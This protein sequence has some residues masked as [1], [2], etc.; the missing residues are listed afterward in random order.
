[1]GFPSLARET[2][3]KNRARRIDAA[4]DKKQM[5]VLRLTT[6]HLHP[7]DEDLSPGTPELHPSDEDLSPGTPELHP[8]DEDLSLG[9][10]EL[11]N[12]WGPFSLRMTD[13]Y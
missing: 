13:F 5:Q 7:S 4:N 1:M 8:S 3:C 10:P 12:A 9:T 2:K 6:P 11:K